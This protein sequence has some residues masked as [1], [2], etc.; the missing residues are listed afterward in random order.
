[1]RQANARYR[2]MAD[3]NTGQL[4]QYL[5]RDV[6]RVWATCLD[7]SPGEPTDVYVEFTLGEWTAGG[8]ATD[9]QR[10]DFLVH[11]LDALGLVLDGLG[12][13]VR[14]GAQKHVG[15]HGVL[16]GLLTPVAAQPSRPA[17]PI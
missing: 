13:F 3:P 8:M 4:A 11:G 2:L 5:D 7:P 9:A 1:M 10:L 14:Q 12:A 6:V 16:R 17:D 15:G